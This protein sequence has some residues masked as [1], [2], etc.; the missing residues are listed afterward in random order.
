MTQPE[1][2]VLIV[3]LWLEPG[4]GVRASCREPSA[5]GRR[6]FATVAELARHLEQLERGLAARPPRGLR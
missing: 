4:A 6:Y 2:A 5:E 1:N 3:R